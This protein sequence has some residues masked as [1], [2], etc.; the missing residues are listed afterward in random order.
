MLFK[1]N[2]RIQQTQR[3][4]DETTNNPTHQRKSI[5]E[6][7]RQKN[8]KISQKRMWLWNERVES[9]IKYV[10]NKEIADLS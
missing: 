2:Q 10:L 5:F 3:D 8:I 4:T 6:V 7:V 9:Q 1:R